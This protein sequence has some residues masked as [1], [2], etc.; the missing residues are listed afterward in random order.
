LAEDTFTSQMLIWQQLFQRTVFLI[1]VYIALL[2][3]FSYYQLALY[4]SNRDLHR[5]NAG[6][7]LVVLLLSPALCS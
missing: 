1:S 4:S 2:Y 3:Q 6:V 5:V 7:V